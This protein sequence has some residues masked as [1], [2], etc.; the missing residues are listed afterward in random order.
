V[1]AVPA[2]FLAGYALTQL[3]RISDALLAARKSAAEARPPVLAGH[4][5]SPSG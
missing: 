5:A 1:V 2:C 3:P 4:R